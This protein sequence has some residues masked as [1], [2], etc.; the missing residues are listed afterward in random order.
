M[1][2]PRSKLIVALDVSTYEEARVIVETLGDAV[3]IYKVGF[4]QFVAYG[5]FIVR[6]LQAQG[7]KVFLDLKFHDIPNTVASGVTSAVGL[8]VAPHD[9]GTGKFAPLLMLTVHTQGGVEM[10]KAAAEAAKKRAAELN[11]PRPLIVGV[12]VLTSDAATDETPKLVLA[13]ARMAKESGLDGVVAS[14]Q[15]AAM[16]RKECGKDF[17]I[18]TPG[19]RMA[20]GAAGDQKRVDTPGG[21]IKNGSSFLV[22]GRP[23]VKA[24]DPRQAAL[25][26]LA[27][28][29]RA[30]TS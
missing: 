1:T 27:D 3:E 10:M 7:K 21:A 19:I 20:D 4:Q 26:I 5:P 29:R 16:L 23:I 22:V 28:M 25:D 13:R 2:D 24:Q 30:L 18:V 17:V 9:A 14:V 6:Y 12:T 15:E 11:V 8:S